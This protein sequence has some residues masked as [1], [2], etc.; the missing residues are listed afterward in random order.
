MENL[1]VK[2]KRLTP[3]AVVPHRAHPTDAG[4]DLTAAEI[5][6]L[7]AHGRAKINTGIALDIPTGYFGNVVGRSGNTIKRGILGATG[8]IDSGYHDAISVMLF[9]MTDTDITI[10]CGER[11]GQIIIIPC[12]SCDFIED[13][14]FVSTNRGG[15]FG[16]TGT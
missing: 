7:P 9:N 16:S 14:R 12:P 1:K 6:I 3:D 2:F 4:Y 8:I 10:E 11:V 5:C 15:G 13:S